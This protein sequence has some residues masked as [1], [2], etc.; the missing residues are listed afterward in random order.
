MIWDVFRGQK[1]EPVLKV[2]R[3]SNI[4]TEYNPNNM[5]NYYQPPDCTTNTWA[6]KFMK[7]R[8]STWYTEE[9]QRELKNGT[10]IED[11]GINIPLSTMKLL[12]AIWIIQLYNNDL[13]F[14]KGRK[15]IHEGG[16]KSGI[17]DA[18]ML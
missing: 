14:E 4:I 15:V 10:L 13:T 12:H 17:F 1:T 16:V 7:N 8:F 2:L 5:T 6:R 11:I 3:K 18:I 9:V